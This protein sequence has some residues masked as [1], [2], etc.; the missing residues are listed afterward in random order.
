MIVNR[1]KAS[2]WHKSLAKELVFFLRFAL[3]H[4]VNGFR[5]RSVLFY[6]E[7]P[8]FKTQI[9]RY[10]LGT[11][12]N[13]SNNPKLPFDLVVAWQ[14]TTHRP[15]DPL[16]QRLARTHTVINLR[17]NDISKRAVE[18]ASR[19]V[20]GYGLFVDPL[21]HHGPCVRKHDDNGRHDQTAIVQCPVSEVD[22]ACVYQRLV[23]ARHDE[24]HVCDM[25]IQVCGDVIA[26]VL[27]R[28]RPR[29]T[30]FSG[31]V[32]LHNCSATQLLGQE[33]IGRIQVLARRMGLDYGEIDAIRDDRDGRLYVVDVNTTPQ[34][35][36]PGVA[37]ARGQRRQH[38]RQARRALKQQFLLP[39]VRPRRATTAR[40]V[41]SRPD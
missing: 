11:R 39:A 7:F 36:A 21:R 3:L 9:N 24:Q 15:P 32:L 4:V 8:L 40:V 10:L 18:A 17:C 1:Y 2:A 31:D 33:E 16:L 13:I 19:E 37:F 34:K 25:R 41:R 30:P 12:F 28:I 29:A 22:P 23:D 26:T 38:L 5:V 27:L 14:D 6:P 20:F 35:A